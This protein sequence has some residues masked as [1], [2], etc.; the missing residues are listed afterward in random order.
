MVHAGHHN[1]AIQTR[2]GV[3]HERPLV[4]REGVF[5][6]RGAKNRMVAE[7]MGRRTGRVRGT[8]RERTLPCRPAG[9]REVA[10]LF[11]FLPS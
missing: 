10:L 4:V 6:G 1:L 5:W 2:G 7:K 11:S 9:G 3:G 8:P